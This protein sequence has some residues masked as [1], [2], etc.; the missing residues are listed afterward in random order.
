MPEGGLAVF[1]VSL[2]PLWGA[3]KTALLQVNCA[4][5]KVPDERQVEGI[6]LAFEGGG[7]EFDQE[8]GG[9]TMFLLTR[10]G[11]GVAPGTS[12]PRVRPKPV[13]PE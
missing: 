10:P 2:L 11:A 9:R 3:S 1:R 12:N 5:G 4:L 13:P 8:L 6:R 7:G